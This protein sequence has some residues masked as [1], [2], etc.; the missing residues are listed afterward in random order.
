MPSADPTFEMQLRDACCRAIARMRTPKPVIQLD[1]SVAGAC[2]REQWRTILLA[3]AEM[4]V[5]AVRHGLYQR[6]AGRIGITLI[7]SDQET[8]LEVS[9]DGWGTVAPTVE[10]NGWR[11]LRSLGQAS[12]GNRTEQGRTLGAVASLLVAPGIASPP[13]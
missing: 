2:P 3:A 13:A 1:I 10:G 4:S 6:T 7:C 9:D 11:T 12:L 8:R 5:N